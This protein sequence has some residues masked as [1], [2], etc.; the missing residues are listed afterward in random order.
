MKDKKVSSDK[1]LAREK[2]KAEI[3][4]I[5]AET[6]DISK[7]WWKR[8]PIAILT[9]VTTLFTS[10]F[11]PKAT[12]V[13]IRPTT[14][15]RR[16]VDSGQKRES[17]WTPNPYSEPFKGRRDALRPPSDPLDAELEE[18]FRNA[19]ES[20]ANGDDPEIVRT[21]IIES[22]KSLQESKKPKTQTIHQMI[23]RLTEPL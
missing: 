14:E 15:E 5:K 11:V 8:E 18:I 9:L 23:M 3:A 1:D 2:L 7:S 21:K 16:S 22:L 17:P 19:T 4:K 20:L 13:D 12:P 10:F 6:K